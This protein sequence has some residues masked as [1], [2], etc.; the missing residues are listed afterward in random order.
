MRNDTWSLS[1][2][3]EYWDLQS[4]HSGDY[5]TGRG[6]LVGLCDATRAFSQPKKD[7]SFEDFSDVTRARLSE[8]MEAKFDSKIYSSI[9]DYLNNLF[10]FDK[11]LNIKKIKTILNDVCRG[12]SVYVWRY[13]PA[14]ELDGDL[15]EGDGLSKI[16]GS[17]TFS[18][19]LRPQEWERIT[20][21]LKKLESVD[22]HIA[23]VK[24]KRDQDVW[25]RFNRID[26][27]YGSCIGLI[28]ATSSLSRE[29]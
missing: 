8:L 29:D 3:P 14:Y 28:S 24:P 26:C 13:R 1:L 21:A 11:K 5:L 25:S 7:I 9:V 18:A 23:K 17:L 4:R 19:Y 16:E 10:D 2:I 22:L 6:K 12:Q 15:S 20:D 27:F